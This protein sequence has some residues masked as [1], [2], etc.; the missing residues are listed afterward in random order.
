MASSVNN[1]TADSGSSAAVAEL[2]PDPTMLPKEPA[3]GSA[4]DLISSIADQQIDALINES[5]QLPIDKSMMDSAGAAELAV[6]ATQELQQMAKELSAEATADLVADL[7]GAATE[8]MLAA[9]SIEPEASAEPE[10]NVNVNATSSPTSDASVP[11]QA[12]SSAAASAGAIDSMPA[13][14]SVAE[15]IPQPA[16]TPPLPVDSVPA[17]GPAM[18]LTPAD[19]EINQDEIDALISNS[20]PASAV[21]AP[22]PAPVAESEHKPYMAHAADI[23]KSLESGAEAVAQELA[24]DG[25]RA[26]SSMPPIVVV[27]ISAKVRRIASNAAMTALTLVNL[28]VRN[29]SDNAREIV[30]IVAIVTLVNAMSMLLYLMIFR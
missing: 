26:T 15:N 30:G 4:D 20:G 29:L 19:A 23:A 13:S 25:A 2:M 16:P 6:Q 5:E 21:D 12:D 11:A 28:P 27:P 24:E 10:V 8:A 17:V 1:S 22:T 18:A 14:D 7:N 3:P 9:P